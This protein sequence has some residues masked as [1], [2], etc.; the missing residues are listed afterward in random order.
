MTDVNSDYDLSDFD[1]EVLLTRLAKIEESKKNVQL[2]NGRLKTRNAKL[3][4]EMEAQQQSFRST[5]EALTPPRLRIPKWTVKK[6]SGHKNHVIPSLVLSD[7]HWDET[8]RPEQV[9]G[10]NGYNRKIAEVRLRQVFETAIKNRDVYMSSFVHD[11]ITVPA[12][13]DLVTGTIHDMALTND[14]PSMMDTCVNLAT[15]LIAGFEMLADEYGHVYAFFL[16]GNHDRNAHFVPTK[17]QAE[18]AWTWIIGKWVEHHFKDDSRVDIAV[19]KGEEIRYKLYDT[20]FNAQHGHALHGG[21]NLLAALT[22]VEE[23]R[24][25]RDSKYGLGYDVLICGHFHTYLYTQ[26]FVCNGT[27]KGCDEYTKRNGYDLSAPVQ[28]FFYTTPERGLTFGLP[29]DATNKKAEAKLW[30]PEGLI[31]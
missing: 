7:L 13:G 10:L 16:P 31:N 26:S 8:V 12:I 2:E 23:E 19:P 9:N 15:N 18:L 22:K 25:Q 20:T 17:N 29:I 24:R 21:R 3:V 28:A 30:S 1:P 4:R 6:P 5:Q 14:S 27:L 11:G